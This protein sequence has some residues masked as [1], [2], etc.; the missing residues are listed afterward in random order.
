MYI[1]FKFQ[2]HSKKWN[3]LLQE[4]LDRLVY[5]QYNQKL[6]QRFKERQA[7]GDSDPIILNDVDENDEW[8]IP[9]EEELEDMANQGEDLTWEHVQDAGRAN[10]NEDLSTIRVN[11]SEGIARRTRRSL[12][13]IDEDEPLELED[14]THTNEDPSTSTL[15]ANEAIARR[16]RHR[17]Q[18][19]N[20]DEELGD[21]P[22]ELE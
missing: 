12:Q 15:D 19:I 16:T 7:D 8:I 11:E 21:S 4:T 10:T 6:E 17:M 3:R 13:L 22:D 2:L 5:I 9:T 14:G 1:L 20:E 18:I